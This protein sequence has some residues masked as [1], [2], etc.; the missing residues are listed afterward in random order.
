MIP[1][2][3]QTVQPI[4]DVV[5]PEGRFMKDIIHIQIEKNGR[6]EFGSYDNF[7]RDCIVAFHGVS[8]ELLGRL[9]QSGVIRTWMEPCEGATRWHG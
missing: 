9:R 6:L 1:L 4:L 8:T 7:H 2:E 3:Q 5:L